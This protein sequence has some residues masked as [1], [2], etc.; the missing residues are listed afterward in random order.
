MAPCT[1]MTMDMICEVRGYDYALTS[2][3]EPTWSELLSA[4]CLCVIKLVWG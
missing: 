2:E 4:L 1:Y 3:F